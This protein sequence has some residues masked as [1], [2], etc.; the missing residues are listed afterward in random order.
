VVN[1]KQLFKVWSEPAA[2]VLTPPQFVIAIASDDDVHPVTSSVTVQTK[3]AVPPDPSVSVI[4]GFGS[5]ASL[6]T[7]PAPPPVHNPVSPGAGVFP[8]RVALPPPGHAAA[9][10]PVAVAVGVSEIVY[11]TSSNTNVPSRHLCCNLKT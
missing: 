9:P 6:R 11:V 2:T 4:E 5:L 8:E 7:T 10:P 1:K 3:L